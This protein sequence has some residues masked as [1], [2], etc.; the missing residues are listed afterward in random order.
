MRGENSV[1]AFYKNNNR[2][3]AYRAYI[4][5]YMVPAVNNRSPYP[6]NSS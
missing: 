1:T 5:L 2:N 3:Q 6:L 4:I